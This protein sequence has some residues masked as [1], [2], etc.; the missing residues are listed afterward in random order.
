MTG[1]RF[2]DLFSHTEN[3]RLADSIRSCGKV[4]TLCCSDQMDGTTSFVVSYYAL[5]LVPVLS[6]KGRMVTNLYM[7][8]SG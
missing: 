2:A 3:M 1:K 5:P 7:P 6:L 8:K 4:D